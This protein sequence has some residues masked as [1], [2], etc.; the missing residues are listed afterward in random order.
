MIDIEFIKGIISI[1][2]E[3]GKGD[4][5]LFIYIYIHLFEF[6]NNTFNNN[7]L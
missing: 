3:I 5:Y 4:D 7:C 2:N 1:K 6:S